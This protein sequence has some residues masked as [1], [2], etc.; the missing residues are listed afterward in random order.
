MNIKTYLD[1]YQPTKIILSFGYEIFYDSNHKIKDVRTIRYEIE[2]IIAKIM[3]EDEAMHNHKSTIDLILIPI[4]IYGEKID[5]SN[6]IDILIED[7]LYIN[8]QVARDYHIMYI[9]LFYEFSKYLEI[10]NIE[11]LSHSILTLNG[12]LLNNYGHLYVC[13]LLLKA[14]HINNHNLIDNNDII[15]EEK[16]VKDIKEE[17][18]H[19]ENYYTMQNKIKHNIKP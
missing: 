19:I 3:E 7:Y 18:F 15:N 5:G 1:Y 14:F 11:N 6:Q 9:E 12:N 10:N 8:Q 4:I 16:R 2:S 17:I 13:L